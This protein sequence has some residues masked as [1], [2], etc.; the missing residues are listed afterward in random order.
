[1]RKYT[2]WFIGITIVIILGYDAYVMLADGK[3]ASVSQVLIDIS[4]DYPVAV[5]LIGFTMGHLFWR[6][7]G[8]RRKDVTK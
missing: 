6:M 2:F 1:M 7:G 8:D 5:F 4:Y 3:E